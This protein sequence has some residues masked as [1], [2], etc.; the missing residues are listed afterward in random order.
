MVD[1]SASSVPPAIAVTSAAEDELAHR[2]DLQRER[3]LLYVAS[4][5]AREQAARVLVR[6]AV[7]NAG[8]GLGAAMSSPRRRARTCASRWWCR[9]RRSRGG[10]RCSWSVLPAAALGVWVQ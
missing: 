6:A 9:P 5:R 4:T 2:Q 7:G 8:P 10:G 3:C 1:V